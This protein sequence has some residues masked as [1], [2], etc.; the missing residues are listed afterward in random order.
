LISNIPR[1]DKLAPRAA[2]GYLVG[3]NSTN[4][5]RIWIPG[6][7]RVITTRDVTFDEGEGYT[8][9][10]HE[11]QVSPAIEQVIENIRIS[12]LCHEDKLEEARMYK[13]VEE[14]QEKG[15]EQLIRIFLTPQFYDIIPRDSIITSV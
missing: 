4:I 15:K 12:E 13:V 1:T 2:I 6:Q 5:F 14:H 10:D 8:P 3:Y 7:K 11:S 9:K